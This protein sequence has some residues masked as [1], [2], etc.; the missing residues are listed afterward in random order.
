M[1]PNIQI[2]KKKME[3]IGELEKDDTGEVN[4]YH[5]PKRFGYGMG[6]NRSKKTVVPA[7]PL[8][9]DYMKKLEEKGRKN[10]EEVGIDDG[11]EKKK[12]VL[13]H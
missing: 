7:G 6:K 12:W 8:S 4:N 3:N 5:K 9:D 10:L 2:K 13:P 11:K 1:K